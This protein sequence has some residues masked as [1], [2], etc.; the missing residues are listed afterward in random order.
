MTNRQVANQDIQKSITFDVIHN[1]CYISAMIRNFKD[2]DTRILYAGGNVA[3]WQ[4][5]RRQAERR[6]QIL[7]AAAR[8]DDL[9]H[10]PSNRFEALKG[11]RKGQ[12]SIR[13][14]LQWRLCFRWENDEPCD[15]EMV[16]YH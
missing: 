3:K 10:L 16:D 13:V 9:R 12:Y 5:V 6:L 2:K 14:N 4:S 8:L 7:D 1:I 11:D 15:V